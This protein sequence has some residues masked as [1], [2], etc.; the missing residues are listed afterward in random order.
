MTPEHRVERLRHLLKELKREG[1]FSLA[2]VERKFG[3]NASYLSQIIN[4]TVSFGE[5]AARNMETKIGLVDFYFDLI[6]DEADTIPNLPP[7]T[8]QSTN[9]DARFKKPQPKTS[10]ILKFKNLL[11]G[12][13]CRLSVDTVAT[14]VI[15]GWVFVI[16]QEHQSESCVTCF[17][18]FTN[19]YDLNG[20]VDELIA[21]M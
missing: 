10:E 11:L 3:V 1:Y 12:Q 16:D 6:N 8:E 2:S 15:G 18:P 19:Q 20:E 9:F 5:R 14:R 17:V 13:S 4:G 21:R 7:N